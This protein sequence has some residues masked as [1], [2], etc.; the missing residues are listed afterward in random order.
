MT[1]VVVPAAAVIA[2]LVVFALIVRNP[3][4]FTPLRQVLGLSCWLVTRLRWIP[5]L[6]WPAMFLG[7]VPRLGLGLGEIGIDQW[8]AIDDETV[9]EPGDAGR[10]SL[11]VLM[12]LLTVAGMLTLQEYLGGHDAYARLFPPD[13]SRYWELRGFAW[14]SGWRVLG[15]V[16]VPMLVLACLPGQRIRDYH[17]SLR[18]FFRHLWIYG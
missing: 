17:I 5:G 7:L 16:I 10:A 12:V 9:R 13:G 3:A 18:G 14:W 4:G 15:Y 11:Q 1:A 8:R 2:A 6:W